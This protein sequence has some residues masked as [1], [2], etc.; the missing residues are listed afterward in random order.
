M[1][2][3]YIKL[4]ARVKALVNRDRHIR[5]GLLCLSLFLLPLAGLQAQSTE[6]K[7]GV[8]YVRLPVP[9]ATP[10]DSIEVIEVF[11]YGCPHCRTFEGPLDEWMSRM[12]SDVTL[13][14]VPATFNRGYQILAAFY[15]VAE[16]LAVVDS[17]HTP[18]FEAI[19]D[20]NLNVVRFDIAQR[21]FEDY[22]S[23]DRDTFEKALNSFSVQTKV[24]QA[25][26]LSRVIRVTAV[27]TIVV[28]GEYKI[29][30][31][32]GM[33]GAAQLRIAE[34]LIDMVRAQRNA[35]GTSAE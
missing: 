8:H 31:P 12:P 9:S 3:A 30:P 7:E 17:V 29:T 24:R 19:H 22:A 15:Y 34:Q 21:L 26:A 20:R 2:P 6:F 27:P 11:S 10:E 28:A 18:I 16:Q 35:A 14:R 13:R 4:A 33:V 32:D 25:D 23:V 5:F 1:F